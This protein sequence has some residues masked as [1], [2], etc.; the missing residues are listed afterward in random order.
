MP[1][2]PL[3]CHH[4]PPCVLRKS[5]SSTTRSC[6]V[7]CESGVDGR[8][9]AVPLRITADCG[10]GDV[11]GIVPGRTISGPR[12]R[13]WQAGGPSGRSALRGRREVHERDSGWRNS[14]CARRRGA[15]SVES[16]QWRRPRAPDITRMRSISPRCKR[17]LERPFA[18][19]GCGRIEELAGTRPLAIKKCKRS[20]AEMMRMTFNAHR[21]RDRSRR[22]RASGSPAPLL[23]ST[24]R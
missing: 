18:A 6:T 7:N 10:I 1:A 5:P 13:V 11:A 16:A 8:S 3:R 4:T 12:S 9:R 15:R 22:E 21:L 20:P 19:A 23:S 24:H 2:L 17:N 14:G